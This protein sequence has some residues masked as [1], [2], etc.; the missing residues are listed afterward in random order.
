MNIEPTQARRLVLISVFA[1]LAISAYRGKLTSSTQGV[2]FL[3]RMWGVGVVA[4]MLGLLADVAPTV[5]GPFAVLIV[6]GMLTHGGDQ[7]LTNFLGKASG[8]G[9]S[10]VAPGSISVPLHNLSGPPQQTNPTHPG[11]NP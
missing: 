4:I 11:Q 2:G 3:K 8:A 5:A 9:G 10:G 7:A 1:M 6:L